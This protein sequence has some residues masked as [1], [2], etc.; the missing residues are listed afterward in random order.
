MKYFGAKLIRQ[1]NVINFN[2]S[3]YLDLD[4]VNNWLRQIPEEIAQCS[5][6]LMQLNYS[7]LK[8]LK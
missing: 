8:I 7:H 3:S 1:T 4:L 2:G 5:T 6:K